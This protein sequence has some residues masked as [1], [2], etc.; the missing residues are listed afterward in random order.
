LKTHIETRT[1]TATSLENFNNVFTSTYDN[2]KIL[3]RGVPSNDS[4]LNLRFRVSG[5]DNSTANSYVTQNLRGDG[6]TVSA[7]RTTANFAQLAGLNTGLVSMA[8][9]DITQ[10]FL[11]S[12][13]GFY[14]SGMNSAS[15]ASIRNWAGTHNQ[16]TSYDG[17]SVFPDVGN[18]T[19]EISIYGYRK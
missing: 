18:V 5:A 9:T 6:T 4:I 3:F 11:A 14:S 12:P 2:Y 8:S 1:L 19:G 17:F 15:S 16:S 13:S 10:P 7:S